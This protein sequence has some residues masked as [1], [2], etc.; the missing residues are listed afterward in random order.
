MRLEQL[1]LG[2]PRWILL[3]IRGVT[4]KQ[5]HGVN[6]DTSVSRQLMK[7]VLS[8]WLGMKENIFIA[9]SPHLHLIYSL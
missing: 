7:S 3:E 2:K 6:S 1:N 8:V 5:G 9:V 4:H